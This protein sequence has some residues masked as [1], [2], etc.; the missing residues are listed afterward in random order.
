L[1]A[2]R[3]ASSAR[4]VSGAPRHDLIVAEGRYDHCQ[5]HRSVM[6]RL[7]RMPDTSQGVLSPAAI[8]PVEHLESKEF[9]ASAL[10]FP[11]SVSAATLCVTAPIG[12]ARRT[13][14]NRRLQCS[15]LPNGRSPA[16]SCMIRSSS[17]WFFRSTHT[18]DASG[19]ACSQYAPP[20]YSFLSPTMVFS[21][22]MVSTV[23]STSS[24]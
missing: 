10:L 18:S 16:T 14:S 3:F 22:S 6:E 1:P 2:F 19:K 13:D 7:K 24:P 12:T 15:I 9:Q 23:S 4:P 17:G 21:P 11:A 8:T 20:P 5:S